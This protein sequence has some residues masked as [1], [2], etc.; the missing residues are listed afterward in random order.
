MNFSL[1]RANNTY[2]K[3]SILLAFGLVATSAMC[4][5]ETKAPAASTTESAESVPPPPEHPVTEE[6][7][8]TF[9]AVTHYASLNRRVT[10][11]KA[12]A[13]RSQLPEWYP[14][15]VWD[16]IVKAIDD[17]DL[18]QVA[19]GIYQKYIG[20]ADM[21]WMNKYMATPSGQESAKALLEAEIRAENS[22]ATPLE[23][24]RKALEYLSQE[25]PSEIQKIASMTTPAE[26]RDLAA[27]QDA[28][29]RL[30]LSVNRIFP[31][32][33]AALMAKQIELT[34]GIAYKHQMEM[35]EAKRKYDAAHEAKP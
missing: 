3:F 15:P 4:A 19:L 22:G 14:Q 25:D 33:S 7:L 27:H 26:R 20:Q 11:A 18:P 28:M 24:R 31:E 1:H 13:Q 30:Q 23:A 16:E 35:T 2:W 9:F 6:Q 8:R 5:Q 12:E 34:K 21:D 29:R 17:I 32:F 10:H